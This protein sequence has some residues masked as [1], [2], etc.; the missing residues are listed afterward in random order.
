MAIYHL[1]AKM[2]TRSSGRSATASAA[3]RAGEKIEDERTGLVFDYTHKKE[4][5][6]RRIFAPA[7][8]P[9][10]MKDR[11]LLWNAVEKT[12]V[13]KDAQVAREV[14]VS[15]PIELEP[16]QHIILLERFVQSRFVKKGMVADVVIHNKV[17]NPHA[18]ILLTTRTICGDGFGQ[19]DR[20]WNSKETLEGWR[21]QW[22][23]YCNT[24][25]MVADHKARI[26]HRSLKEQGVERIPT[27]HVGPQSF[28]MQFKGI[29]STRARLNTLI[30]DKNQA[31]Q[32][33]RPSAVLKENKSER[34]K[35]FAIASK[36]KESNRSHT[37]NSQHVRPH[38]SE[39][40]TTITIKE[41]TSM[42]SEQPSLTLSINKVLRDART[43]H[44]SRLSITINKDTVLDNMKNIREKSR[45]STD[46]ING[47]QAMDTIHEIENGLGE[48]QSYINS[49]I[50]DVSHAKT[51]KERSKAEERLSKLMEQKQRLEMQLASAKIRQLNTTSLLIHKPK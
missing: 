23:T 3:Y 14:E 25:L 45:S 48:I 19:K 39:Y 4:V 30:K 20:S 44:G 40:Q 5:S 47:H 31:N 15:L 43:I 37:P 38:S 17:G 49:A 51:P 22:A 9:Q 13:R 6:Y 8:A 1:S 28:A 34:K 41:H 29:E 35:E 7:N 16:S 12:E 24:R 2:I 21:E 32:G 10:W 42:K 27:V 11:S 26:D 46:E 36:A 33:Y 18:H 50:A